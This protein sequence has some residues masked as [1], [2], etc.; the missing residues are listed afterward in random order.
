MTFA[1]PPPLRSP[2]P[3]NP[4]VAK[5]SPTLLF[6]PTTRTGMAENYSSAFE[7]AALALQQHVTERPPPPGGHLLPS[8]VTVV[9]FRQAGMHTV[10]RWPSATKLREGGI[11][12]D[13]YT[14][15]KTPSETLALF[16]SVDAVVTGSFHCATFAR[17]AAT[18]AVGVGNTPKVADQFPCTTTRSTDT[19]GAARRRRRAEGPLPRAQGGARGTGCQ[20]NGT[21]R[22]GRRG[23]RSTGFI[24]WRFA[25]PSPA[26]RRPP[27]SPT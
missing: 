15:E 11:R 5:G 4:R 6:C 7:R 19:S 20:G 2:R 23:R 10:G 21:G 8:L 17:L 3:Y 24:S 25:T 26:P 12:V 13:T 9:L 14:A 1:L 27:L 16:E 22:L 18:P